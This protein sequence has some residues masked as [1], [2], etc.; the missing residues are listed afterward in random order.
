VCDRVAVLNRGKLVHV[1]RTADLL[2]ST[3]RSEIV[4]K[5]ISTSAFENAVASNGVVRL[6]LPASR[7]REV[8]ERIWSSGGEVISV[9]PVRRS[10]E[11]IFL[12]V[13]STN[14][15]PESLQ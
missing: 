6:A 5:G 2:I 14:A 12:Q 4:A 9:N 1:W 8:I 13:T 3:E 10:L 7:Q 15:S 11:D